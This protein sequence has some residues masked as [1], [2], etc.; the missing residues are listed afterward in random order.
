LKDLIVQL[1]EVI[2]GHD[3][4]ALLKG[5]HA[6]IEDF[7]TTLRPQHIEDI[8][9]I[10]DDLRDFGDIQNEL[11]PSDRIRFAQEV[12]ERIAALRSDGV[13]CFAGDYRERLIFK[14]KPDEPVTWRTIVVSFR[15]ADDTR[16]L[17]RG[18]T[19]F[20]VVTIPAKNRGLAF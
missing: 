7:D 18:G 17:E 3:L 6:G 20:L 8:A 10:F 4:F 14:Q 16:I 19:R 13:V 5:A 12:G 2:T 1:S 11:R 15:P 9:S